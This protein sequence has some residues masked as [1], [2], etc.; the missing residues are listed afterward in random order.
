MST[1]P[2]PTGALIP[3]VPTV[4][5]PAASSEIS[6]SSGT[7]LTL[8]GLAGVVDQFGS[9]MDQISRN[10]DVLSRNMAAMQ[11]SLASLLPPPS[12]HLAAATTTARAYYVPANELLLRHT[13]G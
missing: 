7:A 1:T 3:Q 11:Q 13:Q 9:N 6:Q 8:E 5:L 2:Q 10:V 12:A 4:P